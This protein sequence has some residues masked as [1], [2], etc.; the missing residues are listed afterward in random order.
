MLPL[1]GEDN[2]AVFDKEGKAEILRNTFFAGSHLKD[3]QFDDKFKEEVETEVEHMKNGSVESEVDW[4]DDMDF[5][6]RDISLDDV[7]A[8]LQMQKEGIA[9]G[10]DKIYSELMLHAGKHLQQSIH[11]IYF[12]SWKEG[13]IPED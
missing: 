11:L 12:K 5:L 7:Q 6:N 13:T 4:G 3:G 2:T 8:V 1:L 9:P 10:S